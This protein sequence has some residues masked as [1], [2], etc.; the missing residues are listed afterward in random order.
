MKNKTSL[1]LEGG[2]MRG[3]Y[4]AGILDYFLEKGLE[5]N[6]VYG[7]SAGCLN[8]VSYLSKQKGRN[9]ATFTNYLHN[10]NYSGLGMFLKTGNFFNPKFLYDEI[11][12]KLNLLDYDTFDKNPTEF[13]AVVSNIN[14]GKAEYIKCDTIDGNVEYIR[15]SASLPLISQIVKIDDN[16]YL[17]GGVCD[18]IPLRKSI[19]D[20]NTKNVVILTQH[21]GFVKKP[22]K[23]LEL[24]KHVYKKYPLLYKALKYRHIM[25]NAQLKYIYN[26][27][28]TGQ[29][30]VIQP[31]LPL[32]ISRLEKDKYKLYNIYNVGYQQ[33]KK[34][35]PDII[36]YLNS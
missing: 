2:G 8:A 25:Y 11:P 17:D 36:K 22:T 24:I 18:S 27:Q 29:S 26:K 19:Q 28:Q 5:F 13:Y 35:Y 33:A 34:I 4:T 30:F 9:L 1:I 32:E 23:N 20:G 16:E 6:C 7:V 15:A 31:D 14:T 10:K 12:N 21:K 3:I